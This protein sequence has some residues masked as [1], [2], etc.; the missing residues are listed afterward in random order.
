MHSSF[1]V[2]C[3]VH[4]VHNAHAHPCIMHYALCTILYAL[5]ELCEWTMHMHSTAQHYSIVGFRN[6]YYHY[7][8]NISGYHVYVYYG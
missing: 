3:I 5:Y 7:P 2:R 1:M 6:V 8:R 4:I